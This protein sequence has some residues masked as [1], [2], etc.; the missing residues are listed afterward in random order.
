MCGYRTAETNAALRH[1]SPQTGVAEHS[2]HMEGHA[3]DFR[4]PGVSTAQLRDAA[5]SLQAGGVG[6]YPV[7]SSC[8]WMW[9]RCGSGCLGRS[10]GGRSW[11]RRGGLIRAVIRVFPGSSFRY[12]PPRQKVRKVFEI[13]DLS[14]DL[15][16][17]YIRFCRRPAARRV[18]LLLLWGHRCQVGDIQVESGR[19]W[20]LVLLQALWAG[21]SALL[22][23]DL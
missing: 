5:L 16:V 14:P 17:R 22:F 20:H 23:F 15:P 18:F 2:Q 4:V 21:L 1:D 13:D 10:S 8:M 7:S 19:I 6:Y 9:A 12:P 11:R 3:I